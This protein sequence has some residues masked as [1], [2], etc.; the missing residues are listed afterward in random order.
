MNNDEI[1][2]LIVMLSDFLCFHGRDLNFGL[3]LSLKL[4]ALRRFCHSL[5]PFESGSADN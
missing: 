3:P 4:F 1:V 5:L 2:V